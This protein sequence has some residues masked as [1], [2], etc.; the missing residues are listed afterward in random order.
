[1]RKNGMVFLYVGLVSALLGGPVAARSRRARIVQDT[2]TENAS[3]EETEQVTFSGKI[4]DAQGEP[5]AGAQ[6][7][8][9]DIAYRDTESLFDVNLVE[10]LT[11]NADGAFSFGAAKSEEYQQAVIVAEK[12]GLAIGWV[13]WDMRQDKQQDIKLGDPKELSGLVVDEDGSPM[14]DAE[15][16][17]SFAMAGEGE[18]QRYMAG[19]FAPKLLSVQTD[20]SGKFTFDNLPADATFEL[21]AKKAGRATT[22]TFKA[23]GYQG[24]KLQFS[25][26]QPDIKLI[27]PIEARIEGTVVEKTSGKRVAGV[28]LIVLDQQRGLPF[29]P[30]TVISRED[31]TF[32]MDAL[33]A[34]KYTLQIVPQM[35]GLPDWVADQVEVMTEQGQ[36]AGGVKI[37]L[38]KGG[39][40]EVVVTEAESK[41]PVE[42]ARV[43]VQRQGGVISSGGL[44]DKD[45]IVRIRLM[46]GQY[47]ILG[48]YKQGY[49]RARRQES[50]TIEEGATR[51]VE[52]LLTGQPKITGVVRDEAGQPAEGVKFKVLPAGGP[53]EA[54]SDSQGRFEQRWDPERWG[55]QPTV[56]YL[57]ARH[58]QRNLAAAVEINED[59]KTVDVK[60]R[61]GVIFTGRVV[62]PNGKGI[63]GGQITVMLRAST[64]GSSLE[65]RETKT[66]AQG[67]FEVNAI[68]PE[69]RYNLTAMAEGYGQKQVEVHADD[70]VDNRLDA[71]PLDLAI[72]NLSVSGVVVDANDEPVPDARINCYGG[73]SEGQPDRD[74]RA[75]SQGK[76][77]LEKVCDGRIRINASVHRGQTYMHGNVETEGGA[78]DVR[79]VV[80][81]SSSSSRFVPKQPPSLLGKPLPDLADLNVALSP[82]DTE[83]KLILVCFWDMQ[84]RP[85]RHCIMQ[86]AKQAE[87]LKQTDV[88]V[89]AVQASDLNR[90][91]LSEWIEKYGIPFH[92]GMLGADAQKTRFRWGVRSLPWLILADRSHTIR[93]EGFGLNDVSSK[94]KE[95]HDAK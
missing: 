16:N 24:G 36:T 41:Q 7:S 43:N 72:A 74:T 6:V 35:E 70:A 91:K 29:D 63:V 52:Y 65:Y 80:S 95:I 75:D 71:G 26:G 10:R 73:G 21:M 56:H 9:H 3:S 44:S 54:T 20:S 92:A 2:G 11:T 5:I 51:R 87:Q 17:I 1:M 4:I 85:S 12:E 60:L 48:V 68:P 39:V 38:S 22:S 53:E 47:E 86:L 76:F 69:H 46:P 50:A 25:A 55:S 62:D 19:I 93:A 84:Q 49:A 83:N 15:V 14:A 78:T 88:T 40:L 89:I 66:D 82:D 37:E 34:G 28:K 32:S 33:A 8:L 59:T 31:G 64:W 67:K 13:N 77:T 23:A 18:D 79:I 94:I 27:V 57:V 81:E 30:Q 61:P 58:K 90:E 45:G 42:K